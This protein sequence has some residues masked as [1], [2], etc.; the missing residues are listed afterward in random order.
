MPTAYEMRKRMKYCAVAQ[1][2]ICAERIWL[3]TA[4]FD[5]PCPE[6]YNNSVKGLLPGGKKA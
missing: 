1:Y 2:E 3:M 6:E 5:T 4:H